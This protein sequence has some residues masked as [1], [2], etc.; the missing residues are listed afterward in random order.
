MT[1]RSSIFC[2]ALALISLTGCSSGSL[3]RGIT[4]DTVIR[5]QDSS[6][7]Y[8][9]TPVR[10]F[11]NSSPAA[12]PP[13]NFS[14]QENIELENI[15]LE[16]SRSGLSLPNAPET[17]PDAASSPTAMN[18]V[19]QIYLPLTLQDAIESALSDSSI[20]RTLEGRVNI[21]EI[22]PTDVAIADAR[23]DAERGRFQPE[24]SANFDGSQVNQPPNAF[25]GPGIAANTRRDVADANVRITQPLETGGSVSVGIGRLRWSQLSFTSCR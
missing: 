17:A 6:P 20:V 15:E 16:R 24:L 10:R 3:L 2:C 13:H 5:G 22:T 7:L 18:P 12:S 4:E 11:P 19:P 21:A 23:I 9:P 8:A 14:S 1:L 25:F